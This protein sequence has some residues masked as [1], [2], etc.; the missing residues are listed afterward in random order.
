MSRVRQHGRPRP[1]ARQGLRELV[2]SIRA[3]Y[4]RYP[5]KVRLLAGLVILA[6]T[7]VVAGLLGVGVLNAVST[8]A[9]LLLLIDTAMRSPAALATGLI[10]VV[11]VMVCLVVIGRAY[12]NP[13]R[14]TFLLEILGVPV[15][16][17]AHR[18]RA[19]APWKT[20]FL[21]VPDAGMPGQLVEAGDTREVFADPREPATRDYI[22]GRVG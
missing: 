18:I 10:V 16:F 4:Y 21:S 8:A 17:L 11:W 14:D 1:P 12:P 2:W 20:A 15:A 6:V 3:R 13:I 7:G 19:F 9:V 5:L 22:T